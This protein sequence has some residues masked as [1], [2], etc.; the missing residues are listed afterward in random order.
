MRLGMRSVLISL[1]LSS[2]CVLAVVQETVGYV[3]D[4]TIK[5]SHGLSGGGGLTG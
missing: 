4:N 3:D 2:G 1:A 5:A